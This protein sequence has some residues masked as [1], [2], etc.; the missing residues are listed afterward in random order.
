MALRTVLAVSKKTYSTVGLAYRINGVDIIGVGIERTAQE[1][2]EQLISASEGVGGGLSTSTATEFNY[3]DNQARTLEIKDATIAS[4][5]GFQPD[6][7]FPTTTPIL[8]TKWGVS[9]LVLQNA[10]NPD[11]HPNSI[12][13]TFKEVEPDFENNNVTLRGFPVI[14]DYEEDND[15]ES[16]I[17]SIRFLPVLRRSD[18]KKFLEF[19]GKG[20]SESINIIGLTF[21][22]AEDVD[23]SL[24]IGLYNGI[25]DQYPNKNLKQF[26]L[27]FMVN[28]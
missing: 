1:W 7:V 24:N 8:A 25:K 14:S 23:L 17:A 5:L 27:G 15:R 20:I 19:N 13:E 4:M 16:Y 3:I 10:E 22:I 9:K 28:V 2:L 11:P 26:D 18:V 21:K 12:L 6:F